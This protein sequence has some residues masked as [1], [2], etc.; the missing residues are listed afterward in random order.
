[1]VE[2]TKR[3]QELPTGTNS[4]APGKGPTRVS[5]RVSCFHHCWSEVEPINSPGL[6]QSHLS[7]REWMPIV[8]FHTKRQK[9]DV[10]GCWWVPC[11]VR[12]GFW[13]VHFFK[14]LVERSC[15]HILRTTPVPLQFGKPESYTS[16]NT[17]KKKKF[18][19]Q[20]TDG[21]TTLCCIWMPW[22]ACKAK[23]VK[24]TNMLLNSKIMQ[25]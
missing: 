15:I 1:M 19:L 5:T 7:Q 16:M 21:R 11:P 3:R 6:L 14:W 22:M 23:L 20:N 25:T 8:T 10:S 2:M 24:R 4:I 18:S 9:P 13:I 12:K 17:K